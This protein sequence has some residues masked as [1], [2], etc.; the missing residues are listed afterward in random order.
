MFNQLK[1]NILTFVVFSLL[2]LLMN[3]LQAQESIGIKPIFPEVEAA[4][5][6]EIN[7]T[8]TK[9]LPPDARFMITF[10][11]AFDLSKVNMAG[12][13]SING[14]F[15]TQVEDSTVIITRSGLG[16]TIEVGEKVQ[17]HFATV[18]NPKVMSDYRVKVEILTNEK[19]LLTQQLDTVKIM[20]KTE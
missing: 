19:V 5:I 17:L 3:N 4:S 2:I 11:K 16:R 6:Y 14:G 9:A 20:N 8:P 13:P 12:S 10:P 18:R 1:S 15:R 7:F